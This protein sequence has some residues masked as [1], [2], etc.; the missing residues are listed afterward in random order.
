[1][2]PWVPLEIPIALKVGTIETPEFRAGLDT[3]YRLLITSERKIEFTRL[4]CLLGLS[5]CGDV[6]NVIE[7]SWK[8]LHDGAVVA[9]GSS[10]DYSGGFYSDRVAREIGEFA[11]EKNKTYRAIL[12]VARDGAALDSTAPRLLIETQP[13]EWKDT[14]VGFAAGSFFCAVGSIVLGAAGFLV[15]VLTPVV[16]WLYQ[17][18]IRAR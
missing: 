14:V 16:T 15:L 1:M 7:I 2:H 5:V 9:S 12:V 4:E 8:V 11:A 3:K 6:R 13:W 18:Y 10:R 17:R